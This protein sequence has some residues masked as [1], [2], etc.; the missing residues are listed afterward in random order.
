MKQNPGHCPIDAT[1]KRVNVWL[2]NGRKV[3]DWSA[4]GRSGCDWTLSGH[5][6]AIAFYEVRT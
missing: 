3:Q 6:F 5:A 1:G 2:G 4:D